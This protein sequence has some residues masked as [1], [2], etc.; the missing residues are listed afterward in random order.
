[1]KIT[2]VSNAPWVPSGYGTQTAQA[3]R[4]MADAGHDVAIS[5]VH[6]L[7]WVV[8]DWDGIRCY[9][10]GFDTWSNDVIP[11]WHYHH[12]QGDPGWVITL[13]D[14]WVFKSPELSELNLASWVPIDHHPTPLLVAEWFR[15]YGSQPIAMSKFGKRM[16][17]LEGLEPLYV[18]HGIDTAAFSPRPTA[19]ARSRTGLPGDAFV[20]GMV[21]NNKGS[22][23]PRKSFPE[24]FLAFSKLRAEHSD[25]LLYVHAESSGMFGGIDLQ[26][27]ADACR[28]PQ[29]ALLFSDQAQARLGVDDA[30]MADLYSSFDV[31]LSPSRGEG[32]GIPVVEAQACGTP[33]IVTDAT[34][35]TELAGAGWLVA[36]QPEWDPDQAA[37]W[38]LPDIGSILDGLRESY[39]A[40]GDDALRS[41]ARQFA[42]AYDADAVFDSMWVPILDELA[43]RLPSS[44]PI[45]AKPL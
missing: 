13:C 12:C 24:A 2:W 28:I 27:L 21:A 25:A 41:E 17:E 32:F 20:V 36:G 19:E 10:S 44:D 7:Q 18:P 4:R 33:V 45:A 26:L 40:R 43:G 30:E 22:H 23:P 15:R 29:D 3:T 5:C 6:G 8:R 34:A 38:T 37:W 1:V 39:A 42:L 9:P 35:Q 14:V 16:L 31:L 11:G